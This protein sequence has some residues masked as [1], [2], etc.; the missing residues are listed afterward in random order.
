MTA[1]RILPILA[2]LAGRSRSTV[3]LVGGAVR[4]LLLGRSPV[5]LDL[6][7]EGKDAPFLDEL[8]KLSGF[9]PALLSRKEPPTHRISIEGWIIDVSACEPD[10]LTRELARRD[11]TVNA[12]AARLSADPAVLLR[13]VIDPHGGLA[14]IER[15]LIRHVSSRGLDDDPLRVLRAVRLV[16]QLQGF[17]L[18]PALEDEIRARASRLTAAAP[19]RLCGELELILAS[20]RAGVGLRRLGEVGL[21][22]PLFPDLAPLAGL[23]QNRWHSHDALEHTLLAVQEADR[24]VSEGPSLEAM[25]ALTAEEAEVLKWATVFHDT[26]KAATARQDDAGEVHFHGHETVSSAIARQALQWYRVSGAK[27]QRICLL[28]QHHLRLLLLS[29]EEGPTHRA[30]RRLVHDLGY[31][32]PLVCMLALADRAGSGGPDLPARLARLREVAAAALALMESEG[33]AV[34]SPHPLLT[35]REVM[36]TLGIEPGPRVG[37]ALRWLTRLQIDERLKTREDALAVL[38]SLPSSTLDDLDDESA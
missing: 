36:E 5:D 11:F 21:L 31:D 32:T 12:L 23:R 27:T 20:P 24:L 16:V 29:A 14:D 4:D 33:E 38:K 7:V 18:D 30:L 2:G 17:D 9:E 37:A 15:R 6:L 10:G 3:Y 35:G 26:G 1:E 25:P 19:E 22:F 8:A 28:V 34:I 13:G